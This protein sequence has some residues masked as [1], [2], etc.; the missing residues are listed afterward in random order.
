[1]RKF[2][3]SGVVIIGILSLGIYLL[4]EK[5]EDPKD[6]IIHF[7]EA[8][9]IFPHGLDRF[10][11]TWFEAPNQVV[12]YASHL[13]KYSMFNLNWN[14]F[15]SHNIDVKFIFYY[16]GNDLE[17]LDLFVQ[18]KTVKFPI[19]LDPQR[20]FYKRNVKGDTNSIAFLVKNGVKVEMSNPSFPDFQS[21]L[22]WLKAM[23]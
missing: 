9:V 14:E 8:Q 2:L 6:E 11:T 12:V 15:V 7:R 18:E 21:R 22:D 1:M 23:N 19:L 13:G 16:S 3:F 4:W 20:A 5:E 17:E 10:D